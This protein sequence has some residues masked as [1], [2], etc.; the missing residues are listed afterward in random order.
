MTRICT[1]LHQNGFISMLVGRKKRSSQE[2]PE[3]GFIQKRLYCFFE[4]GKLFYL[5][6]NFRLLLYLLFS[7]Y[8]IICAIDLDSI[9]PAIIA[10]KIRKKPIVYDAHEYFTGMEEIVRRPTIE[11]IWK[12]V[13]RWAVPK[14][15]KAYTVSKGY[16][17]LFESEYPIN[18][19]IIRNATIL[20]EESPRLGNRQFILYQGAVN[21]GRGLFELIEA[22]QMIDGK[23]VICGIGDVYETLKIKVQQLKLDEKVEFKGFVNP[24]ELKEITK[25]AKIGITI[26]TNEGLS[27]VYS[28]ANRFFDYFHSGVPQIAMKY[29]EYEIVVN[30]F[31]VGTLI[32]SV[33]A[34]TIAEAINEL[35]ANKELYDEM[36]RATLKAREVYNWQ[37]EEKKLIRIYREFTS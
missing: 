7:R 12:K 14:V 6:Y 30:E 26:F 35:L 15:H 27:N 22:M 5:E 34:K 20:S 24:T 19:E 16:K 33:S 10:S 17:D 18:F 23:L 25:K 2:L 9:V 13:E 31:K 4:N 1:S 8:D 32:E 3:R 29:P 11:K 28:M 21:E 36:L 37:N